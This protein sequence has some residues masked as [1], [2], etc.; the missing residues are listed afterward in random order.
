MVRVRVFVCC[1]EGS[2]GEREQRERTHCYIS[3]ETHEDQSRKEGQL[4]C[5]KAGSGNGM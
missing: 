1:S 3:I 5:R 2:A 4:S